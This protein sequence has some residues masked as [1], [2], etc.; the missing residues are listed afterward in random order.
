MQIVRIAIVERDCGGKPG[1]PYAPAGPPDLIESNAAVNTEDFQVF[2]EV[3]G[4]HTE[5]PRV[6]ICTGDSMIEKHDVA[7]SKV[8]QESHAILSLF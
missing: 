2:G 3:L 7:R 4:S 6:R 8:I 1:V 5:T